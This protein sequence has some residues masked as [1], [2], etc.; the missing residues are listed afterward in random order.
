MFG[1]SALN[2]FI[3]DEHHM[4]ATRLVMGYGYDEDLEL[5]LTQLVNDA[6]ISPVDISANYKSLWYTHGER[7]TSTESG[8]HM[9][10]AKTEQPKSIIISSEP[11]STEFD[12]WN[13][14]PPYS[15]LIISRDEAQLKISL[16]YFHNV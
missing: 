15:A 12:I 13:E 16:R 9:E 4:I 7:Y 11:L 14:V 6:S 10:N 3:A 2:F 5:D 8:W 1:A